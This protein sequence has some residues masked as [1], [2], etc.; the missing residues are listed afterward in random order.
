MTFGLARFGGFGSAPTKVNSSKSSAST[1][2][3]FGRSGAFWAGAN[4]A[5]ILGGPFTRLAY[6]C[7]QN[8]KH[9]STNAP[10]GERHLPPL[11]AGVG[12]LFNLV[13]PF[14]CQ[15]NR[16]SDVV[17][18]APKTSNAA[19]V[20]H[21]G[22]AA[23]DVQAELGEG[24]HSTRG[25]ELQLATRGEAGDLIQAPARRFIVEDVGAALAVEGV[26]TH[27]ADN[28]I[29]R[30]GAEDDVPAAP[31]KARH[32]CATCGRRWP[33]PTAKWLCRWSASWPSSRK[34]DG[35]KP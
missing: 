3:R 6:T 35:P 7:S 10:L 1:T 11:R 23:G 17:S 28:A 4:P 26:A 18:T 8:L 25:L 12:S 34:P 20:V 30:R 24:G 15:M 22:V 2:K 27:P 13:A 5:G 32:C 19:G 9:M 33:R 29:R 14:S 31:S 21:L 16:K